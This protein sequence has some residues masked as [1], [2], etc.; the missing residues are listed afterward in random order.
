MRKEKAT[1]NI[2]KNNTAVMYRRLKPQSQT[3][4]INYDQD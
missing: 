2:F 3:G 1:V 4:S